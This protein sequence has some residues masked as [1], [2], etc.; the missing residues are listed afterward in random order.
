M[1]IKFFRLENNYDLIVCNPPWLNASFVFTQNDFENSVY[2]PDNKFL[3]SAFNFASNNF[4]L[5][6][7][8]FP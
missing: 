6:Y 8:I 3:K 5:F 7:F 1:F 2:D 4:I